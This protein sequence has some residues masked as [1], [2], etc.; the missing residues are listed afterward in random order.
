MF[1]NETLYV[2][3]LDA[4]PF[5]IDKKVCNSCTINIVLF[6]VFFITSLCIS[7]VF[8]CFHWHLRKGNVR[9]KLNPGTQ[10]AIY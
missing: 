10:A 3:S 2:I 5:N 8:I 4:I 6:A 9:V 7:S 1:Y